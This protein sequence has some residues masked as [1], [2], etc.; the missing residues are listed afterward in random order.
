MKNTA[1]PFLAT[2]LALAFSGCSDPASAPKNPPPECVGKNVRVAEKFNYK[3]SSTLTFPPTKV[4]PKTE[5]SF[6]WSGVSKSFLGHAVDPKKDITMVSVLSWALPRNELESQLNA[7]TLFQSSLNGLPLSMNTDGTTAGIAAGT[8]SAKL[9]QFTLNGE[10]VTE[11]GMVKREDVL[12]Y[13]D[14]V[15]YPPENTTYTVM[16]ASGNV[17]GQ[18]TAMI[19]SF[20]LDKDSTNTELRMTSAST[21]LTWN[22]NIHS[23]VPTGIPAGQAGITVDWTDSIKTNAMGGTFDPTMILRVLVGH[24]TEDVAQLEKKFLDIE[25]IAT[26]LYRGDVPIGTSIDLSTLTDKDGKT[27]PG[28][29]NTGTWMLALQCG[30]CHN[31]APWY[32][33][34][35]APMDNCS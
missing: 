32:L 24:Y 12:A 23:L 27:F 1:T 33:T 11:T 9:F 20:L 18:G 4:Q 35:L 25:L 34:L 5:L 6:D 7:D 3:F 13:F 21:E 22:A 26:E 16:A 15:T 17:I 29:N 31:P 8:T 28:I 19:Q 10:P 2:W 14:P 30:V